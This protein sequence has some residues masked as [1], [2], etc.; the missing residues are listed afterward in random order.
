MHLH[1]PLT[2][3]RDRHRHDAVALVPRQLLRR[4]E[5]QQ[6]RRPFLESPPS[7]R[8]TVGSAHAPPSH[9]WTRPSPVISAVAPAFPEDGERR[10]TTVAKTNG[11]PRAVIAA[12]STQDVG[13]HAILPSAGTTQPSR[14]AWIASQTFADVSGM[15]MFFTPRGWSASIT[16]LT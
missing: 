16:A 15:S 9:P 13:L 6:S 11:S 5:E 3:A 10:H 2:L 4:P 8:T 7:L 14:A 1:R 12:T